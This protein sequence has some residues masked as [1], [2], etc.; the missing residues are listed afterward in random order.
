MKK[1]LISIFV[2]F[3]FIILISGGV[4]GAGFIDG[5][6]VGFVLTAPTGEPFG[7][8][9]SLYSTSYAC[10]FTSPDS[11][12]RVVQLGFDMS[13][14]VSSYPLVSIGL[15]NDS[16]GHP[17]DLVGSAIIFGTKEAGWQ[18]TGGI[19]IPISSNTDYWI[20]VVSSVSG[21]K[22][23]YENNLSY[24]GEDDYSYPLDSTWGGQYDDTELNAIYALYVED[25]CTQNSHCDAGE[26][27]KSDQT[28]A[29]DLAN[30]ATCDGATYAGTQA[31]EDGAC[32]SGYCDSDGVGLADDNWCFTPYN[33][34]F[35]GQENTKCEYST[36]Q[37]TSSAD[38]RAVLDDVGTCNA[39]GTTYFADEVSLTCTIEDDTASVCRSSAHDAT[40]TAD[41]DCDGVTAGTGDCSASCVY[42]T[43]TYGGSGDWN[44]NAA[45]NCVITVD[46]SLPAN[47]LN[48][49]GTGTF[50]ILADITVD[51]LIKENTCQM[52][53]KAGDGNRLIIKLG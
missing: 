36:D 46:T 12:M 9:K 47:T 10:P 30:G 50:T 3:C 32:T 34:Y 17:G 19:S 33:T 51:K 27:C 21:V 44:V 2:S 25:E 4:Y 8:E 37:G 20:A 1:I 26:Y 45:D 15:Y 39:V 14:A 49:Y 42:T 23:T 41:A 48:L 38:E 29:S 52:I 35:D 22:I 13:D 6:D 24:P 28:C 18:R 43:C 5:T 31:E 11:A 53:N 16:G 40:C 7:L